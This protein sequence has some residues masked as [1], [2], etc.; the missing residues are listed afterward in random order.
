MTANDSINVE[1]MSNRVERKKNNSESR[2]RS[3]IRKLSFLYFTFSMNNMIVLVIT[4]FRFNWSIAKEE[5]AI[6]NRTIFVSFN[7]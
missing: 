5:K 2:M 1:L 4:K 7:G 6:E 3:S